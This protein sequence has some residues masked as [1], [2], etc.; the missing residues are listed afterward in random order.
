MRTIYSYSALVKLSVSIKKVFTPD[1][2]RFVHTLCDLPA[3]ENNYSQAQS[4]DMIALSNLL[5][6]DLTST[7]CIVHCLG[8][9]NMVTMHTEP[10]THTKCVSPIFPN[11]LVLQDEYLHE[12]DCCYRLYYSDECTESDHKTRTWYL[13]QMIDLLFKRKEELFISE[14][15]FS[16]HKEYVTVS[17]EKDTPRLFIKNTRQELYDY[18]SSDL[19]SLFMRMELN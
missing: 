2:E 4:I 15:Q 10:R 1:T 6:I 16:K 18:M 7:Y 12:K 9:A 17:F 11:I 14:M 5:K 19:G 8:V 13:N 3:K